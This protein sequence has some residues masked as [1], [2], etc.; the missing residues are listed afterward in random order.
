M[1]VQQESIV[2]SDLLLVLIAQLDITALKTQSFQLLV[3]REPS[4]QL[5]LELRY[6]IVLTVQLENSVHNLL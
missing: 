2:Q 1:F 5:L 3:Q 6:Q 4:E